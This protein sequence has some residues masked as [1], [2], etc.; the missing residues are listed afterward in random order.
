MRPRVSPRVIVQYSG[1]PVSRDDHPRPAKM[2]NG[3]KCSTYLSFQIFD[4]TL[5]S[6]LVAE[7]VVVSSSTTELKSR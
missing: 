3:I 4:Q 1:V 6:K 5:K 7:T 2:R